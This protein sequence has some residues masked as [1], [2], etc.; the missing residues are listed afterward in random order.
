MWCHR[1]AGHASC[2]RQLLLLHFPPDLIAQLLRPLGQTCV[3]LGCEDQ[4]LRQQATCIS[5]VGGSR[6]RQIL[7]CSRGSQLAW[8]D[9]ISYLAFLPPTVVNLGNL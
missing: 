2:G 7:V 5:R 9:C 6:D 4:Q 8:A 3:Q 1:S